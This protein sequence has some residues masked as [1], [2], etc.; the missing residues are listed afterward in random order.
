MI[1][2]VAGSTE[3]SAR[4]PEDARVD[5]QAIRG[6]AFLA[7][8]MALLLFLPAGTL[9]YWQGWVFLAVFF[10]T[11]VLLTRYLMK[12]N[13]ALLKR[14]LRGGPTAEKKRSQKI[15]MLAVSIG[16]VAQL[17]VPALDHRFSWTH[18]PL[19]AVIAGDLLTALGFYIVFL[20]YRENPFSSATVEIA[21]DQRVISTGPYAIVRHPMYAGG[22]L[23][24]IGIPLA[25]ASWWGLMPLVVMMPFLIWRLFD[26]EQLL[27]RELP[28]Y[29]EYCAKVRWRMIPGVF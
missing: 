19:F 10:G 6:L 7:L 17:V 2:M 27:S 20:V 21:K 25:L 16:F 14:R 12:Y 8:F 1:E 24:L 15:I 22:L 4:T 23:Y 5:R 9:R 29:R 18:V 28:G 26:E 13:R 11:S 3:F